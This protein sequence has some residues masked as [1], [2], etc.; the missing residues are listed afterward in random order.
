MP[1]MT[2]GIA[3]VQRLL[4]TFLTGLAIATGVSFIVFP[5][6]C[7]KIVFKEFAGYLGA[8]QGGLKAHQALLSSLEDPDK[9]ASSV[10]TEAEGKNAQVPEALAVKAAIGAITALH[11]K[12]QG[13]LPF[14]KREIALGKLD[15]NDLKEMNKLIRNIMLPTVGLGAV[16][17]IFE[18]IAALHGWTQAN[19]ENGLEPENAELRR[20]T[21]LEWSE[22]IKAVHGPFESIIEVMVEGLEH[23]ALQLELKKPVKADKIGPRNEQLVDDV[24]AKAVVTR[25]GEKGFAAYMEQKVQNFNDGKQQSMREWCARHGIQLD[26]DFFEHPY[27]AEFAESAEVQ[28]QGEQHDRNQRQLYLLLYVKPLLTNLLP[29]LTTE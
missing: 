24:E 3:F 25:P 21:L 8:L 1:T 27:T 11:G 15:A 12:L 29:V 28:H 4:E 17:D 6:T 26:A 10:V 2:S 5:V 14:A 22:N 18:R 9:L 19:L 16:L 7:R 13:D 23:V 20:R